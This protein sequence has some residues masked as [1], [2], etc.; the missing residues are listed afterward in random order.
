MTRSMSRR[1]WSAG[2]CVVVLLLAACRHE[3]P[4]ALGTLE[5]D[6]IALPAPAAATAARGRGTAAPG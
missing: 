1:A 2:L 5:F 4:S 6:R 3:A